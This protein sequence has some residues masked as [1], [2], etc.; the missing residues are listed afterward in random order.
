ME[1]KNPHK[2][3]ITRNNETIRIT[4]RIVEPTLRSILSGGGRVVNLGLFLRGLDK[5]LTAK[6][7]CRKQKKSSREH[8][9]TVGPILAKNNQAVIAVGTRTIS[10]TRQARP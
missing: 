4:R 5:G 8:K 7:E 3:I 10:V 6:N 1:E 9:G 2:L